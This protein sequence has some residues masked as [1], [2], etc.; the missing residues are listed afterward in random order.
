MKRDLA[1]Y[2]FEL[3]KLS[4]EEGGGYLISY[5]DFSACLSDGETVEKAIENGKAALEE[6]IEALEEAGFPV[7]S[8]QSRSGRFVVRVP[9]STHAQL[10]V[11][12]KAEGVSLNTLVVS[13]LSEGL[14]RRSE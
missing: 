14:G 4:R 13:L 5:P 8:P 1:A 7:P 12:A 10:T 11:R 9:K 3:R 6:T 2:P